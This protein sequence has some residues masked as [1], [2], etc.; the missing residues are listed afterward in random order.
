MCIVVCF[1]LI[2][3]AWI[4]K[5]NVSL[6][7]D[8]FLRR[9]LTPKLIV[10]I[11]WRPKKRRKTCKNFV[12]LSNC[13]SQSTNHAYD[14]YKY[15]TVFVLQR[16]GST[17]FLPLTNQL[18]W[19]PAPIPFYFAY[20][21]HTFPVNEYPANSLTRTYQFGVLDNKYLIRRFIVASLRI[22]TC[23]LYFDL[24]YGLTKIRHNS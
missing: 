10:C 3:Y 22:F 21:Y 15:H 6:T 8:Y 2:H 13:T 12:L 16:T 17:G 11:L 7:I 1:T 4:T 5:P 24:P 23:C 14:K 19:F 9:E 18:A 20:F